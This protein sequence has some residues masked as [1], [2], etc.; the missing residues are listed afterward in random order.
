MFTIFIV[1]AIFLSI[2]A[3][4]ATIYVGKDI[5]KTISERENDTP[6]DELARSQ[7]YEKAPNLRAL[8]I[9]YIITFVITIVLVAIFIL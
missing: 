6:E 9:I 4:I 3:L 5:N 7:E 1:I 2:I 8:S